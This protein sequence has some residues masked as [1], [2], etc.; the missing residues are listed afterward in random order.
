MRSSTPSSTSSSSAEPTVSV[1]V[2]SNAPAEALERCLAALEPQRG[3]GVDVL[4]YEGRPS[5]TALRERF[6]WASFVE[7]PGALVPELWRDGIDESAGDV[8]ALT[9]AQMRPAPG[10]LA[11]IREQHRRYDAVAGAIDPDDGLRLADW[12]EFFCRYARDMRPFE[13]H[14]CADLPGDNAAYKRA[15]LD[16]TRELYRDGFWE[17]VVH[18][19]LIADGDVVLWHTPDVVVRQG[20]SAGWRAFVRQRLEHG[21]MFGRQRGA[22]FGPA[23]GLIGVLAAPVVPFLMSVRILRELQARRRYRLRFVAAFPH[24]L[25]FNA[26]WAF[27]EARGQLDVLKER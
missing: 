26:V 7:R 15:V 2:A 13:G 11:A 6:R 16:R 12:G 4:V 9:I 10:W 14:E 5:P 27:A 25:L 23:R 8:V 22:S 24:V 21:R 3:D 1:V 18:R 19:R 20:P 17:P